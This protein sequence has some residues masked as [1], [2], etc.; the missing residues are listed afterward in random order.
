MELVKVNHVITAVKSMLNGLVQEN[1]ITGEQAGNLLTP[2]VL[3][4]IEYDSI[5]IEGV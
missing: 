3:K 2:L 4:A 5:D 1:V